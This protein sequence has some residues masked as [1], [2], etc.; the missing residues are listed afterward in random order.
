MSDWPGDDPNAI[1]LAARIPMLAAAAKTC[2]VSK[3]SSDQAQLL[4]LILRATDSQNVAGQAFPEFLS[5]AKQSFSVAAANNNLTTISL[6]TLKAIEACPADDLVG[7][8]FAQL[9]AFVS[10]LYEGTSGEQFNPALKRQVIRHSD[11][12]D[13][14]I[15]GSVPSKRNEVRL[16]MYSGFDLASLAL[17][18]YILAHEL[19]CH[20]GARHSG[21]WE[22]TPEPDIRDYFAEGFMDQATRYLLMTWLDELPEL[23]PAGHLAEEDIEYAHERPHAFRAGAAAWRNCE[24]EIRRRLREQ[25]VSSTGVATDFAS[26]GAIALNASSEDIVGKDRFVYFARANR[27]TF[28]ATFAGVALGHSRPSDLVLQALAEELSA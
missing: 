24:L 4:T 8:V 19:I 23:T 6:D 28:I 16:I 7:A 11:R 25:V 12:E 9:V 13:R 18:P 21:A 27:A 22:E 15:V 10:E 1:A 20:I 5:A 3:L 26:K 17:A 14:F 2:P